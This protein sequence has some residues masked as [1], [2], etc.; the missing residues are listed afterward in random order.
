MFFFN[1]KKEDNNLL[2]KVKTYKII[3]ISL[4]ALIVLTYSVLFYYFFIYSE[5]QFVKE[6]VSEFILY[7][8]KPAIIDT[9][10]T[11]NIYKIG[12]SY[13]FTS[14]L[15]KYRKN[16][17]DILKKIICK[18]KI[19]MDAL[20]KL[21]ITDFKKHFDKYEIGNEYFYGDSE[22]M[23]DIMNQFENKYFNNTE[24]NS[25]INI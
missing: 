17:T 25:N 4:F 9:F 11:S 10:N 6:K 22:Q 21:L 3:S 7:L 13:N 18:D 2:Y 12:K 5:K 15:S 23:L 24:S 19:Q 8:I 16:N 1:D 20:E 14:R